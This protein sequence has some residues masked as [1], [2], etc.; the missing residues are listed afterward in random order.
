MVVILQRV[1]GRV[2]WGKCQGPILEKMVVIPRRFLLK[3]DRKKQGHILTEITT[4]IETLLKIKITW[5][6]IKRAS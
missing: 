5:G 2:G 1:L 6:K 3:V 4:G